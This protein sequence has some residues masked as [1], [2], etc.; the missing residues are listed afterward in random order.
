MGG[1]FINYREKDEPYVA[2]GICSDLV[3]RFGTEQVFL[4]S[5]SLRPADHYPTVIR[6]KLRTSEVVLA[7]I[8]PKWL[9]LRDDVTGAK[10]IDRE[11]DWVRAEISDALSLGI[12]VIP[13]L[14]YATKP[15]NKESLPD[16]IAGIATKQAFRVHYS[17]FASDM[18]RLAKRIAELAPGVAIPQLFEKPASRPENWLPSALLRPEYE[19]VPLIDRDSG[20]ANLLSWVTDLSPASAKLLHSPSGRGKT[21]LARR[22]CGELENRGWVAGF[23]REST[24]ATVFTGTSRITKPLLVVIDDAE[25]RLHQVEAAASMLAELSGSRIA[26][27]RVLL[28]SRHKD[29][30]LRLYQHPNKQI[31]DVFRGMKEGTLSPLSAQVSSRE[32][33]FSRAVRAFATELGDPAPEL[34]PPAN[35]SAPRFGSVLDV[36][37][38]ALA[39]LLDHVAAGNSVETNQDSLA[40]L[41]NHEYRCWARTASDLDQARVHIV[42]AAAT[43]YGAETETQA[44]SLLSSLPLFAN[45]DQDE[46]EPYLGWMRKSYPG[47]YALNPIELGRLGEDH[48][49]SIISTHSD[50]VTG[51]AKVVSEHQIG[52]AFA[53]LCRTAVRHSV[54]VSAISDLLAIDPDQLLPLAMR[55]LH[56]CENG[57]PLVDAMKLRLKDAHPNTL[58]AFFDQMHAVG[59]SVFP[60]LYELGQAVVGKAAPNVQMSEHEP[61][62]KFAQGLNTVV[63]KLVNE[64]SNSFATRDGTSEEGTASQSKESRIFQPDAMALLREMLFWRGKFPPT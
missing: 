41:R 25:F 5:D 53:V 21:R 60:L 11:N 30:L 22:L 31:A 62:H 44:R 6:E 26:P 42:V 15:P 8:G 56:G 9:E 45:A 39:G 57:K 32:A 1:V 27:R 34:A 20:L 10:L 14:L 18:D 29:W 55:A 23:L 64:F 37:A 63:E 16:D 33:E 4:D 2:A 12:F 52:R 58:L 49:A 50:L 51:P 36:H 7:I 47:R 48:L 59:P 54:A 61:I 46:I 3:G 28:L 19:V 17:S 24:L 43:L 40:R 13:V 35:L 38:V